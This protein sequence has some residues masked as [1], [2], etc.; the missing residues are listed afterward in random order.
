VC[1]FGT[2][3]RPRRTQTREPSCDMT[4]PGPPWT[5]TPPTSL[6]PT[7]REPPGKTASYMPPGCPGRAAC[8][9]LAV[10]AARL[11]AAPCG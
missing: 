8:P 7:S 11:A 5:G 3:R 9:E 1:P 6:P 2:C 4:G 10:P